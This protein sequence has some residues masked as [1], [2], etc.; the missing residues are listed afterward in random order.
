MLPGKKLYRW[1]KETLSDFRETQEEQHK[2]DTVDKSIIDRKTGQ[3]K[4][5]LVPILK[6]ENM[7]EHLTI[8]EKN[9]NGEVF[10]ILAN[11]VT[12]KIVAMVGTLKAKIL[13]EVL[14][15]LGTTVLYKVKTISK[16]L[17][18]NYDWV[19]RQLFLNAIRVGD[20][21]HIIK[22]ALEALQDVRIKYRQEALKE[23][24]EQYE[25]QKEKQR[26]EREIARQQGKSYQAKKISIKKKKYENGETKKE[27]LA[28]SL[29]TLCKFESQWTSV[30]R[31][32]I[33]ILFREFPEIKK[34]YVLIVAFRNL[35]GSTL[36]NKHNARQKL[37]KWYKQVAKEDISEI[38]EFA[39]LIQRHEGDFLNYFPTRQTNAFAESL[40]AQIQRFKNFCA[41]SRDV[42]FFLY[43]VKFYFS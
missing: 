27:I 35:Y 11:K 41:G 22:L 26:E 32:R 20:K 10:T 30:Q 5:V 8:D 24:R 15:K 34:A 28:R 3:P 31:Q 33:E 40:N 16:D 7:G 21:F 23:E 14:S 42:D 1:Y 39:F 37:M 36:K 25:A 17:A 29:W 18:N 19:A 43:R 4:D 38:N 13:V 2:H 6:P 9:V 12:G